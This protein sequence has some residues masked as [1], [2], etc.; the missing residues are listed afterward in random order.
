[1]PHDPQFSGSVLKSTQIP[2][3][4]VKP[5]FPSAAQVRLPEHANGA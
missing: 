1:L 4:Q 5:G 2:L 3:Q